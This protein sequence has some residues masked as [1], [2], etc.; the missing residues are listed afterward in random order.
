[1]GNRIRVT[2]CTLLI[3]ILWSGCMTP[4]V[5]VNRETVVL[6][7]KYPE[8]SYITA[9]GISSSSQ[10]EADL[11]ARV[12]V[13]EQ[14]R[15]RIESETISFAEAVMR[16]SEVN[17]YQR[18][19]LEVRSQTEFNRAELIRIDSEF[20]GYQKEAFHSFAYISRSKLAE[21]LSSDYQ[22]AA[23]LFQLH[24]GQHSALHSD[25]AAYTLSWR[26]AFKAYTEMASLA[27]M[28]QAVTHNPFPTFQEARISM[29]ELDRDRVSLL[30][31]TKV[32]L[33]LIDNTELNHSQ[34]EESLTSALVEL[35]VSAVS[36]KCSGDA[37]QLQLSTS[38]AW[39][40]IMVDICEVT[41]AGELLDCATGSKLTEVSLSGPTLCGQGRDPLGNL[42]RHA[43]P[44]ALIPLLRESLQH[45]LP[46]D[47]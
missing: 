11:N 27:C 40:R 14:I 17:D 21:I 35:G 13:A 38:V 12:Q 41:L 25:I 18:L 32:F 26:R 15:S 28:I 19:T 39:K 2:G 31:R 1:M 42:Q 7:A 47:K 9:L 4:P 30:A 46:L 33:F 5:A 29:R 16:N 37:L 44:T 36:G 43:T 23:L 20:R 45:V 6:S 10:R 3:G 8:S 24:L 22:D 34:L